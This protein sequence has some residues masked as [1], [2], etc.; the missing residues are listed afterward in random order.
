MN[1]GSVINHES[2]IIGPLQDIM[3]IL[4]DA[5]KCVMG[6]CWLETFIHSHYNILCL[7][8]ISLELMRQLRW[9]PADPSA[10]GSGSRRW[11]DWLIDEIVSQRVS[12]IHALH[13]G[14]ALVVKSNSLKTS[15]DVHNILCP[16]NGKSD[17]NR[18]ISDKIY[19]C[20][21]IKVKY[22]NHLL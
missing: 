6:Q 20:N 15:T 5:L 11:M 8:N 19:F 14:A 3:V 12:Q 16:F 4:T 10:G 1:Q 7:F 9:A 18:N 21:K 13:C 22:I 2:M 17:K